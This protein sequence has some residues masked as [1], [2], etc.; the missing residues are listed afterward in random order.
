M[1]WVVTCYNTNTNANYIHVLTL[2][3]STL[4]PFEGRLRHSHLQNVTFSEALKQLRQGAP[5]HTIYEIG[6]Y[7]SQQE[8]NLY[9]YCC[10]CCNYYYGW[11]NKVTLSQNAAGAVYKTVMSQVCSY[12]CAI[13]VG[14]VASGQLQKMTSTAVFCS[15]CQNATYVKHVLADTGSKVKVK[16][17][18]YSASSWE[19]HL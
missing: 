7:N 2:N 19:P 16:V 10:C 15:I 12:S 17:D 13:S 5:P 3:T 1:G 4:P 18:L 11:K 6:L 8:L 9:Y 14:V